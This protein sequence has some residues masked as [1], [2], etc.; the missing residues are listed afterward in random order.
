VQL[1]KYKVLTTMISKWRWIKH[2]D[3]GGVMTSQ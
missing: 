2:R 3:I 1:R